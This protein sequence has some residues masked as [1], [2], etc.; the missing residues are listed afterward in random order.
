[1]RRPIRRAD[2]L[3]D[4]PVP[5]GCIRH[6]QQGFGK[7]HKCDPLRCAKRKFL[8]KT[9][10]HPATPRLSPHAADQRNRLLRRSLALRRIKWR[11]RQKTR[12]GRIFIFIFERIKRVPIDGHGRHLHCPFGVVHSASSGKAP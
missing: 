12:H 1:M 11:V 4:Q 8:Q 3:G 2:F 6:P 10:H 7:T 5:R 9:F